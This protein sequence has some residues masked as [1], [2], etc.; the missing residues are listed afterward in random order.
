M[1]DGQ[2]VKGRVNS[3]ERRQ[4]ETTRT[5]GH[6]RHALR[7]RATSRPTSPQTTR[8]DEAIL[9]EPYILLTDKKI[10]L[11][12]DLVPSLLERLPAPASLLI[13]RRHREGSPAPWW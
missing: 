3:L 8:A 5:G 7:H 10:G 6:R 4:V 2:W 9:E 13:M 11:V 12:Q 1:P